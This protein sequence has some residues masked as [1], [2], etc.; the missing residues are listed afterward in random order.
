MRLATTAP[1]GEHNELN[2]TEF[3]LWRRKRQKRIS[4]EAKQRSSIVYSLRGK[5]LCCQTFASIVGL[6]E[7]S[8]QRH[9]ENV[10]NSTMPIYYDE[11]SNHHERVS[12]VYTG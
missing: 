12:M 6:H 8:I 4:A 9:A 10:A 2:A 1:R 11:I 5:V 3:V 7:Q